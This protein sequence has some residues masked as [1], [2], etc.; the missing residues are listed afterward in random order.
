MPLLVKAIAITLVVIDLDY[1]EVDF[2]DYGCA[3][4]LSGSEDSKT[5][6]KRV[7]NYKFLKLKLCTHPLA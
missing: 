7:F 2:N 4:L 1:N 3:S 6:F 5:P